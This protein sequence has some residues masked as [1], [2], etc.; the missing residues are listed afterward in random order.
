MTA[1][2][3][4]TW[5]EVPER[6]PLGVLVGNVDLV[7]VRW[8]NN[9]SVLYGRC[10]HRGAKMADGHI[11]GDNLICGVHVWDFQFRTGVSA[12]DNNE[13]LARFASWIEGDDL[14]I[15]EQEVLAWEKAHP[16]PYDRSAYQGE[17]QDHHG[18]PE[19]PH[20]SMIRRLATE[21]LSTL[22]HHGPV[23]AMGVSREALPH[24]DSIQFV[25]AQLAT[26]PLLD[27]VDVATE[28]EAAG[29]GR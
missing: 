13:V 22:G 16:Q 3:I 19:E 27:D 25:T 11:S 20:V 1:L 8:E 23:S 21:G 12:Y 15:D 17:F 10:L 5:S 9:H 24:W 18:A 26:K 2:K 7:I 4:A 28:L 6:K 14:M 29:R